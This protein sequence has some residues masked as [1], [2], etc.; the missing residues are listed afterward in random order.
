MY[1]YRG[2]I[3][4]FIIFMSL[5]HWQLDNEDDGDFDEYDEYGVSLPC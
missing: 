4:L 3:S 5:L 2:V 1:L